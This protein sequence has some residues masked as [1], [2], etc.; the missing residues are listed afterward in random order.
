META[1]KIRCEC[2]KE[3]DKT[4]VTEP[5]AAPGVLRRARVFIFS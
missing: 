1:E 3:A 4:G 5:S 2:R